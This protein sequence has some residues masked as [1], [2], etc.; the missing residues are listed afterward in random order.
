MYFFAFHRTENGWIA[1]TTAGVNEPLGH[2]H[3]SSF[4][5]QSGPDDR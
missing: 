4:H 2:E 1:F 3:N 5:G